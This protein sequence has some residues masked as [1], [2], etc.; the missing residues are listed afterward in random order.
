MDK[1]NAERL[2][3]QEQVKYYAARFEEFTDSLS[4]SNTAITGFRYSYLPFSVF[5]KICSV[6]K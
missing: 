3:L 6:L 5:T 4:K 1:I 2:S